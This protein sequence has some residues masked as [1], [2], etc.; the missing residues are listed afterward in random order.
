L[1]TLGQIRGNRFDLDQIDPEK[2][3]WIEPP[4]AA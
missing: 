3:N 2:L 4:G 1:I